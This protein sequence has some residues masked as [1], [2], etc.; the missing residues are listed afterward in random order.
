M[1]MTKISIV[2]SFR[3]VN[4]HLFATII[5]QDNL[6]ILICKIANICNLHFNNTRG[7]I[8]QICICK[9]MLHLTLLLFFG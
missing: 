7:L 3:K 9:L 8:F 2:K 6:Q 1:L 4:L 5:L